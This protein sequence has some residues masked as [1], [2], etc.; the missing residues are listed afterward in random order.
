MEIVTMTQKDAEE[1][2]L[3]SVQQ[4]QQLFHAPFKRKKA[5]KAEK[6]EDVEI[7]GL[8]T[9][10]NEGSENGESEEVYGDEEPKRKVN[11]TEIDDFPEEKAF[12]V[13]N[14]KGIILPGKKAPLKERDMIIKGFGIPPVE[15]TDSGLPSV[16]TPALKTLAGD[17]KNKKY[18]AAYEHFK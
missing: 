16:D 15:Y 17:V 14:T 18:G 10:G 12:K 1:F 6:E 8:E 13:P 4:L 3:S 9:F 5:P 2:N 7:N 11:R